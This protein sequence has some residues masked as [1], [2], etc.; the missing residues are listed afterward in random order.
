MTVKMDYLQRINFNWY[1]LKLH[2]YVPITL[3]CML[4]LTPVQL[5]QFCVDF[6]KIEKLSFREFSSGN[7]SF[8][9]LYQKIFEIFHL[10]NN[11][12]NTDFIAV[13]VIY[14]TIF[15]CLIFYIKVLF[16]KLKLLQYN[17]FF[18]QSQYSKINTYDLWEGCA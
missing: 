16:L 14:K 11:W 7:F 5:L 6:I 13:F 1:E 8:I 3:K 17:S 15:M 4:L 9:N 18:S 2:I 10:G 12:N